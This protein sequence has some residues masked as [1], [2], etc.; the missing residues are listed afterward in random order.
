MAALTI[1]T[2][3]VI[4]STG[5]TFL[6]A[7][8]GEAITLGDVI[9][10]KASDSKFYKADVDLSAEAATVIGIA[11]ATVNIGG[12]ALI[13]TGGLLAFGAILTKGLVYVAG[14]TAG[15]INP[16]ADLASGWYTSILG[17]AYDASTLKIGIFNSGVTV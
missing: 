5:A 3:A 12:R 2:T 8:A 9:Y 7:T 13:Q 10:Q 14:A 1:T 15:K 17:V 6:E 16:V 11:V 4:P